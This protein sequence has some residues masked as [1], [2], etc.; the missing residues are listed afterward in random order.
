MRRI[1]TTNEAGT[2]IEMIE[3]A[4][5]IQTVIDGRNVFNPNNTQLALDTFERV[6][7]RQA[8]QAAIDHERLFTGC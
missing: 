5:G 8:K 1:S 3:T 4:N 6:Y 2:V 7:A